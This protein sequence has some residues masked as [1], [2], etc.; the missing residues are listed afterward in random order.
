MLVLLTRP[1][2]DSARIAAALPPGFPAP[3]VWSLTEIRNLATDVT[4]APSCDGLVF[5]SAHGVDAYIAAGGSTQT[6]AFCVGPRTAAQARD[7]G[8]G[9]VTESAGRV[10]DLADTV[11]GAGR[12]H[13]TY[14]RGRDVSHNLGTLLGPDAPRIDEITVYAAEPAGPPPPS[15]ARALTDG[16]L[17]CVTLWSTRNAKIFADHARAAG[18]PLQAT[19]ALAISSDAA[20]PLEPLGFAAIAVASAPN[21]EAMLAGLHDAAQRRRALSGCADPGTGLSSNH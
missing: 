12:H 7:A 18:W 16:K 6:P 17:A 19:T 1:D 5:T 3:L 15:V 13:L 10:A 21:A 14:L 9:Q 20:R 8:F 11:L 2:R 4:L